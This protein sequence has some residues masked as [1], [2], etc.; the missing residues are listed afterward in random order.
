M[1]GKIS[2]KTKSFEGPLDLLLFLI[3]KSEVNI[4]DIPISEITD[5]FL[6]YLKSD[7]VTSLGDLSD[8]YKMAAD[9]IWIK[10]RMMLPVEVE[11][12]E[13]YEDPRKELV[14]RLLDYQKFKKYSQLLFDS[15][16]KTDFLIERKKVQFLLP[17]SD[18]ELWT[19]IGIGDL[20][21]TYVDLMSKVDEFSQKVFNVYEEVSINDKIA[22]INELLN[23]QEVV[24]FLDVVVKRHSPDHIIS[25]FLAV[26][27]S[28]KDEIILIRQD[29]SFGDIEITR[30]PLDYVLQKGDEE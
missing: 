14:Q 26:L 25:A 29:V 13:E 9:L 28:V 4:Y 15:E 8:F 16:R 11:F 2:Y 19:D 18:D 5:Q 17:F 27:D 10:S 21:S 1:E 23:K 7:E 22:L 30:R 6:D 20:L 24:H 3:Q 12:D